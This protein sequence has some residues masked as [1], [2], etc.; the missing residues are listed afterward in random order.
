[1]A[2]TTPTAEG[3]IPFDVSGKA[4]STYY[5]VCGDLS[6]NA[7]RVVVLHGGP[8]GAHEYLLSFAQLWP[9]FGLPVVFY[10]QI[11]CGASTHLPET[12][13]DAEFW[14]ESL[15]VA[16]LDNLLDHLKLREGPGFHLLGQSW[17]GLLAAAFAAS[18]PR[19]LHRLVLASALA[20]IELS[21]QSIDL[22]RK[23]LPLDTQGVLDKCIQARDY[24]SLAF[25]QAAMGF[26]QT[27]VCRADPLPEEL[28]LG[29]KHL[30]EDK[31]VYGTM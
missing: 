18:R 1:M 28:I 22:C 15:F 13:G 29:L 7:P 26:Q 21:I 17:G 31:T 2:T 14:Q 24:E 23:Q 25:Q 27:F 9:Q 19:G 30:N 5:K 10:D 8:G 11:G 12:A 20:S 4:C 6:A 3:K 16:E